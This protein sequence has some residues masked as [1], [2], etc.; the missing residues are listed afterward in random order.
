MRLRLTILCV[1]AGALTAIVASPASAASLFPPPGF[2]LSASNGYSLHAIAFDGDPHEKPDALILF[3]VG[4]QSSATYFLLRK[5]TVSASISPA[6]PM[7]PSP[8]PGAA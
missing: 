1:L 6:A 3:V 8:A 4:K 2:R 7:S 5:V